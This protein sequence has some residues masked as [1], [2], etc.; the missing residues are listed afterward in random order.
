MS[1]KEHYATRYKKKIAQLENVICD[2][3]DAIYDAKLAILNRNGLKAPPLYA[4]GR[5]RMIGSEE[6]LMVKDYEAVCKILESLPL[7]GL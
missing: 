2:Y 7:I 6:R 5:A 3:Y 1:K 4:S